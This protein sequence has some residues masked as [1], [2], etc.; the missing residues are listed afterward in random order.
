MEN[1][2]FLD[3]GVYKC[4]IVTAV[5]NVSTESLVTV[6]GPPGPPGGLVVAKI[7]TTS[8]TLQWTD[9]A[10]NG[11]PILGYVIEGR[12]KSNNTWHIIAEFG[13]DRVQIIEQNLKQISLDNV[14]LP[15]C[16][17][18]FVI[19]AINK[20]GRGSS[21]LPS[22]QHSTSPSKPSTF[23][24][25]ISGGGGKIGDL[26]VTWDPLPLYRQHGAGIYY[27]VF[28]KRKEENQ[29]K[30]LKLKDSG[31]T[32][33]AIIQIPAEFFYTEYDVKIQAANI[34]GEGPQSPIV[35]I[36]SA[37]D[38]PQVAPQLVFANAYNSTALNVTWQQ[39]SENR[40]AIRGKLIGYRV[41]FL[42]NN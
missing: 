1:V 17:Y 41:S 24:D 26:T 20:L 3:T 28:W 18:E 6:L 4:E 31:N 7:S 39:I 16:T 32:G 9:G 25:K 15:W 14:L 19:L 27:I 40:D 2:T 37:E 36:Y 34:Y 33:I 13:V 23:P 11:Y 38:M 5:G 8:V 12:I 22:P 30:K 35:T 21:S 10:V 29:F 42:I